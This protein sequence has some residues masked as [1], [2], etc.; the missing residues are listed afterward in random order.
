MQPKNSD[1]VYSVDDAQLAIVAESLLELPNIRAEDADRFMQAVRTLVEARAQNGW[2]NEGED[3]VAVFVMVPHPRQEGDKHGAVAFA[4]P[5][6]KDEPLLGRIFFSN[7]DASAGRVMQIPVG[8]SNDILEWLEDRGLAKM[9]VIIS[10]R[11]SK[12]LVSRREGINGDTRVDQIRDHPP[13]ATTQELLDALK[14][15]HIH[16]LLTPTCCSVGVWEPECA[17]KYVPGPQPE[18][19]IQSSL[20]L[21]L[22]F[23]FR[24]VVKAESED[25]TNIGRIDIRLLMT[26]GQCLKYWAIIELKVVKSFSN[27]PVGS[28]PNK[29]SVSKNVGSIIEGIRQAWAYRVNRDAE[30]GLLEVFDLRKKKKDNLMEYGDVKDTLNEC[31]PAPICNVRPIFGSSKD[32]RAAGFSGTST[33]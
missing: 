14:H 3:D 26:D 13:S 30:E 24:G 19:S 25:T 2:E 10:Y 18:K 5:V 8:D 1:S 23:W 7:R 12:K 27:A 4:D 9:P 17:M 15:F 29:V 11:N 33:V 6:V 22:N 21:A 16:K 28:S 31:V 32:A 20:E